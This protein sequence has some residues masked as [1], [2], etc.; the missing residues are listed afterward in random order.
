VIRSLVP[1]W[2]IYGHTPSYEFRNGIPIYRP[3]YL[4]IP[5][6][7]NALW[8][9]RVAYLCCRATIKRLYAQ[10]KFDA[11]VSFDLL[12]GGGLAW[13]LA[14]ELNIP[15]T[16]WA[17]GDDVRVPRHSTLANVVR[18]ALKRLDVVFYQ[19]S[20]LMQQA[21][22]LLGTSVQKL[23]PA[24]HIVLPH[25]IPEAPV[26]HRANLRARIRHR[27]GITEEKV[28]VL[29]IGRIL[30]EKG[31]FELLEAIS[32]ASSVNPSVTCVIV[33]SAPE[34]DESVILQKKLDQRP[35]LKRH[36]QILPA[37]APDEVW[38]YLCAA[39]V[40]AFTSYHEGMPNSLLEAMAMGVPA[41]AFAIPAV[42]ELESGKGS[43]LLVPPFNSNIFAT[44]LLRLATSASERARI[45]ELGRT[46]VE[47]RYKARTNLGI[48]ISKL[49]WVINNG[50]TSGHYGGVTN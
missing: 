20:E 47:E 11:I 45:S 3:P 30:R 28:L 17:F 42:T 26:F 32:I 4:Q 50:R 39:D 21:A 5:K 41:V 14:R 25:G 1:R 49:R 29:S 13:R 46:I 18:R 2:K 10:A 24:R 7:A 44:S 40:F 35:T 9:D 23:D 22:L 34:F 6:F 36:L 8:V 27:L 43:P 12:A 19:S 33:G 38:H 48:A 15:S 37:C 31:A 16:G